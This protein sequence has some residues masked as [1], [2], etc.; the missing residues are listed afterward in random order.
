MTDKLESMSHC[1]DEAKASCTDE[2]KLKS[3]TLGNKNNLYIQK[4]QERIVTESQVLNIIMC[5]IEPSISEEYLH[6]AVCIYFIKH[7]YVCYFYPTFP[8]NC[9]RGCSLPICVIS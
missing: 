6:W 8:N 4:I 5:L 9:C 3:S 2:S 1:T 7:L